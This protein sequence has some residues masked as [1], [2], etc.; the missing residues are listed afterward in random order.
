MTTP[1]PV[2]PVQY[3]EPR[4][5]KVRNPKAINEI[6]SAVSGTVNVAVDTQEEGNLIL[7]LW[8]DFMTELSEKITKH[9]DAF[10]GKE[11]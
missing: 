10:R 7:E 4:A 8:P 2:G 5:V 9:L 11:F 1:D 6:H 3:S